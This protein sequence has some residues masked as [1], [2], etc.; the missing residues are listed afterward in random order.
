[1]NY[2]RYI[3]HFALKLSPVYK[4]VVLIH[5]CAFPSDVSFTHC[6]YVLPLH[7]YVPILALFYFPV[8]RWSPFFLCPSIPP[9]LPCSVLCSTCSF[10]SSCLCHHL[11][12]CWC[13]CLFLHPS[14]SFTPSFMMVSLHIYIIM[15]W[16]ICVSSPIS[17]L[18]RL[19][20]GTWDTISWRAS[21]PGSSLLLSL[22]LFKPF[23]LTSTLHLTHLD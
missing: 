3:N 11:F 21:C 7:L 19:P 10:L 2:C 18:W 12:I 20:D 23:R 8:N 6:Q 16:K 22:Y 4:K 13:L 9:S 1:M 14:S 5:C 15:P 17:I